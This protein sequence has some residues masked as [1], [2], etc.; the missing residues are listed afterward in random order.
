MPDPDTSPVHG[1]E[2]QYRAAHQA[3]LEGDGR[4][5]A[6]RKANDAGRQAMEEGLGI[7]DLVSLYRKVSGDLLARIPSPKFSAEEITR[8]MDFFR[9][10][11]SPFERRAAFLAEGS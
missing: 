2:R 11:L 7:L 4:E 10:S 6:L 1:L 8:S 9:E 3:F 5:E